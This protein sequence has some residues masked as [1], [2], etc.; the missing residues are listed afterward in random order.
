M[1]V[2]V[3]SWYHIFSP[4]MMKKNETLIIFKR[5]LEPEFT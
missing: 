5:K 1:C 3:G 4:V 2:K